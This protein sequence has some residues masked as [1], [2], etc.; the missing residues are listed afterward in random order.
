LATSRMFLGA[1]GKKAECMCS[2]LALSYR[3]SS[4][5]GSP[6]ALSTPCLAV[7]EEN[8]PFPLIP[9]GLLPLILTEFL[10]SF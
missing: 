8:H 5:A 4:R 10:M 9:I 2:M 7:L 6:A 3:A 1:R